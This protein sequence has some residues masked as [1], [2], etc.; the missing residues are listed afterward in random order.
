[1]SGAAPVTTVEDLTIAP[2]AGGAPIVDAV[3]F[4]LHPGEVLG[5]AGHSGS[6]KSTTAHAL[7]GHLRPGL[8]RLRGAVRVGGI[9]PF[10]PG[11]A[12]RVRGHRATHLG[13]DPASALNPARRLG[14]QLAEAVRLR[15]GARPGR[16]EVGA[17][18]AELLG[19]VGLPSDRGFLRRFP[20]QVS[21]GQAR[22]V[23]LAAAL[24]GNP[25]LLVLDEPTAGLDPV[26]AADVRGM[27][28]ET[29]GQRS[30]V[31][32]S[33]DPRV[34]DELAGRVLK[35]AGGR[36]THGPVGVPP[37]PV[38]VREMTSP[39]R[40]TGALAERSAPRAVPSGPARPPAVPTRA[41]LRSAPT[42]PPGRGAPGLA[43]VGLCA[44][45][46]GTPIVD[47]VSL[48]VPRGGLVALVG[49]S[50]SGKTTVARCVTGLHRPTAGRVE[51]DGRPL[52]ATAAARAAADRRAVALVAQDSV[53][54]L[55]PRETVWT[56]LARPLRLCGTAR[57]LLGAEITRLLDRVRLPA[58]V[59]DRRPG[60]LSGGE[61]QRVN[62]AR[63]LAIGPRVL[64]CD[65]ITSALDETTAEVVT[66]LVDEL[67][68][69]TGLTVLLVTHD[70][71]LVRRCADTAV[72]LGA[73]RVRAEGDVEVVLAALD[74][75]GRPV[76]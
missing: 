21:G 7:F 57:G 71:T 75:G 30:A 58:G 65:E 23:A 14:A 45:H 17:T 60:G 35:M 31:L 24:A 49:P 18:V 44:G 8:V 70:V 59:A 46:D 38:T 28:A 4:V 55:N 66:D 50:G 5:I 67:R 54:A 32:V 41:S 47:G 40:R 52:A 19:A 48:E 13:Q 37:G 69:E 6:G 3:S 74:P 1:M 61:R 25:Q 43:V 10:A 11:G 12:A 39:E 33:H 53:A 36:V 27:L 15:A 51:L 26:V 34:L 29:L 63:A 62:L 72:L 64:V 68:R 2:A 16:G 56:A 76:P 20:H 73:G 9:D 42:R 22:R